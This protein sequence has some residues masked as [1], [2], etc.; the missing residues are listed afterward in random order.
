MQDSTSTHSVNRHEAYTAFCQAIY[1]YT[2]PDENE[3]SFRKSD[4]LE[5]ID[6]Q[7]SGW[8]DSMLGDFRG[9]IPSNYVVNISD[10][11]AQTLG[12]K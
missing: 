12:H 5:V 8:W 11:E 1:D 3:L 7:E 10:E 6:R 9:W 2:A 4:I